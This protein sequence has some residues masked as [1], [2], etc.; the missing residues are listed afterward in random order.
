LFVLQSAVEETI[1]AVVEHVDIKSF[2][3]NIVY[4][5]D[6]GD[7]NGVYPRLF[8]GTNVNANT[9][10][11]PSVVPDKERF[12]EF[13]QQIANV[14][15]DARPACG[16][17]VK[18][19]ADVEGTIFKLLNASYSPMSDGSSINRFPDP[20]NSAIAIFN[21]SAPP[22]DSNRISFRLDNTGHATLKSTLTS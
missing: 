8:I 1:L 11:L 14:R 15:N 3:F 19:T 7:W 20:T 6:Q 17:R 18:I 21:A 4:D 12:T 9:R 2:A 16:M 10:L 13:V 5:L 22:V